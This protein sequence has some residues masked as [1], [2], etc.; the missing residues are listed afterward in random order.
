MNDCLR[1]DD[2]SLAELHGLSRTQSGSVS[3][4]KRPT[5]CLRVVTFGLA[6]QDTTSS[7]D[8]FEDANTSSSQL[9]RSRWSSL[10]SDLERVSNP[11]YVSFLLK[12]LVRMPMSLLA[13]GRNDARRLKPID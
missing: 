1:L 3:R 11:I 4:S 7:S 12:L 9:S 2:G 13:E 10:A 8:L 6:V 5:W